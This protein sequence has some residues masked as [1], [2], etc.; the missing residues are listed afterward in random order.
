MNV[1]RVAGDT[2]AESIGEARSGR[3][4]TRGRERKRGAEERGRPDG[5]EGHEDPRRNREAGGSA[6]R[7]ANVSRIAPR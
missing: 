5:V 2:R 6:L 1:R 7:K 3:G 4:D